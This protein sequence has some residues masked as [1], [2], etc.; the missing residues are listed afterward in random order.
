MITISIAFL[1][2][3][4]GFL[5]WGRYEDRHLARLEAIEDAK[6]RHPAGK[7]YVDE[8]TEIVDRMNR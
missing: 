4:A 1:I 5:V 2:I 8:F 7:A 6:R 3:A